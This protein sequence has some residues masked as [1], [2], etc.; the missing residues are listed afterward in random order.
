MKN[1]QAPKCQQPDFS[2][3]TKD[4]QM[5]LKQRWENHSAQQAWP[6]LLKKYPIQGKVCIMCNI[7]L[8]FPPKSDL[9]VEPLMAAW[10]CQVQ[11]KNVYLCGV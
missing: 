8:K 5:G 9:K 7:L 6:K 10:M 4:H 11:H 1:K 2:L 3:F